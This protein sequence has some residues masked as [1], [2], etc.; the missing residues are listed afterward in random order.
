MSVY[1]PNGTC[2]FAHDKRLRDA[3]DGVGFLTE[4]DLV[5]LMGCDVNL[6]GER[7]FELARA[8]L[9]AMGY[10]ERAVSLWGRR[11]AFWRWEKVA[12]S[13]TEL[14]ARWGEGFFDGDR[15]G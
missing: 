12:F 8:D 15:R 2:R 1:M 3:L 4:R 5:T 11:S 6:C 9:R 13:P 7:D 14:I 10:Q